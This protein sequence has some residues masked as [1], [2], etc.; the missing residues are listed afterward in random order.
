MRASSEVDAYAGVGWVKF[1][2]G[3]P[4]REGNMLFGRAIPL[5]DDGMF[6]VEW[7]DTL[8]ARIGDSER[9]PANVGELDLSV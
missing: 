5:G 7:V 1:G 8:G 9:G 6:V 3:R 2:R 4:S